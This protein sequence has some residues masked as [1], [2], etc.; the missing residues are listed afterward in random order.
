MADPDTRDAARAVLDAARASGLTIACAE[1]C[2]G[3]MVAAAI[4]DI[5]GASDVFL[6][7]LVTYSNT[8]KTRLLA[9]RPATLATHGAVSEAVAREMAEGA[10][11]GAGAGLAVATTG[12]AGPGGSDHKPE[13]RVCFAVA[14]ATGTITETVEFGALGR[15]NVRYAATLHALGLLRDE[16]LAAHAAT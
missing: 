6:E 5:A 14:S 11:N 4:T 15:A 2:T 7:G 1:S 10:R 16:A 8:A 3:G 13:G 12:I 9:V